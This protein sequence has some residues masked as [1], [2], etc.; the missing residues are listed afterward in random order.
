[1]VDFLRRVPLR[2]GGSLEVEVHEIIWPVNGVARCSSWMRQVQ[3]HVARDATRADRDWDWLVEIP[4]IVRVLGARRGA[5]MFQLCRRSDGF[6]LGMVALLEQERWI[7][8]ERQP[9]VFV[10]YATGAPAAAIPGDDKPA[11]LMTSTLDIA[12][13]VALASAAQGRLWLHADPAGGDRLLD[14]Y[15][16]KGFDRVP[17]W[18]SLPGRLPGFR[19]ND[20]RYFR[21]TPGGSNRFAAALE[22][23]RT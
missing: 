7:D 3:P 14:W 18:V 16:T 11:N 15:A 6:P 12:V 21:L 23:F 4:T 9:A 5:R 1:M 13:S 17:R 2:S 8:N 19:R 20:G 22:G 10:W